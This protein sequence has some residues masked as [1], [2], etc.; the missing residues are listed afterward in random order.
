MLWLSGTVGFI[1]GAGLILALQLL[2]KQKEARIKNLLRGG[3][4]DN[5]FMHNYKRAS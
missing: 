4:V 2:N 1:L 3:R 5:F